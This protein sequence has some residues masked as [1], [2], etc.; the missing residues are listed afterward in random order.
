LKLIDLFLKHRHPASPNRTL[1]EL[2]PLLAQGLIGFDST[3]NRTLE[4]LK[5]LRLNEGSLK[6]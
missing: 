3:P 1:E 4:E 2:K 6:Y 5:P